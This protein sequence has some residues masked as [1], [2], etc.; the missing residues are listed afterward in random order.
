MN[1]EEP[2]TVFLIEA[3]RVEIII[4]GDQPEPLAA[5]FSRHPRDCLDQQRTY[6]DPR[7]CARKRHDLAVLLFKSVREQSHPVSFQ[8][9]NEAGQGMWMIDLAVSH[10]DRISPVFDGS[11]LYPFAVLSGKRSDL[12]GKACDG[13]VGM[14]VV[15]V[16]GLGLDVQVD[17]FTPLSGPGM[18][19]CIQKGLQRLKIRVAR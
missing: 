11:L 19:G 6:T 1:S 8:D 12:Q 17:T 7:L 9:G 13:P 5:C 15:G 2:E 3:Q 16:D 10:D 14:P 4:C 18:G